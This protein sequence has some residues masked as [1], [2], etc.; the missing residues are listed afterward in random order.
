[1]KTIIV[2]GGSKGIGKALVENYGVQVDPEIHDEVLARA[3]KSIA[4]II[5]VDAYINVDFE[6][7]KTEMKVYADKYQAGTIHIEKNADKGYSANS[8]RSIGFNID[9]VYLI[10]F[11]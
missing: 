10:V 5:T 1:M 2:V 7:V 8:L 9:D 3:A 11:F 4:E 6:D